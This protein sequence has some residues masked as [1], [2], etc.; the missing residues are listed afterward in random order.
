MIGIMITF[1]WKQKQKLYIN[2]NTDQYGHISKGQ[3]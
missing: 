3:P 2:R 1:E